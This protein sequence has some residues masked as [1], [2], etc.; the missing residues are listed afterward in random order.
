MEVSPAKRSWVQPGRA[1]GPLVFS[2]LVMGISPSWVYHLVFLVI[3]ILYIAMSIGDTE[4]T[5][6][7]WFVIKNLEKWLKKPL[8]QS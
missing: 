8:V 2:P 6:L 5:R 7:V 3:V 4:N 1:N